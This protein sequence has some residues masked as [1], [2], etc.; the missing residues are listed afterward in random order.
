MTKR[1]REPRALR[2]YAKPERNK[3]HEYIPDPRRDHDECQCGLDF[4]AP[5]HVPIPIDEPDLT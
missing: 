2:M 5:C 4:D 1:K 3:L